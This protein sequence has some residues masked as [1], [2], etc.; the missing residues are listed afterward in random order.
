MRK[1]KYPL[2]ISDFDGTL[3][4][5]N[6]EISEE[7]KKAIA[8]YIA[9][10]GA[11]AISTGRL[12]AGILSR[13]RELG[14]K[15][16]VCCCQG[17][18]V[19]DIESGEVVFEDALSMQSTLAACRKMEELDLHIHLYDLWE[20]YSNKDDEPLKYYENAVRR[21]AVR[22]TDEPLSVFAERKGMRAYKL[23]AMVEEE[24][25]KSIVKELEKAN[26]EGCALTQSGSF[27]VEVV[28][29]AYSKAT[30]V[31]L[32]AKHY[33]VPVEKTLAIGDQLND[34]PMIER[35]GFGIA[36][37]NADEALKR[38]ADFVSDKTNEE[39]AVGSIIEQ[40][41]YTEE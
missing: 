4:K 24:K 23:L 38:A 32:L 16:F 39:G 8:D 40:F 37:A 3:I 9:A 29:K 21:K 25:S 20:Y 19:I 31:E 7:N 1:I 36:V 33:G 34:I 13:A 15:G 35:A 10:G 27:L 17:A 11:F 5:A 28:N 22:I 18:I 14:L 2:V 26:I 12:P 6:G 41:V 30:A